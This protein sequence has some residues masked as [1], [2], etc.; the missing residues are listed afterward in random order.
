[1]SN[2]KKIT[3]KTF[4]KYLGTAL[5]GFGIG[6]LFGEKI[7]APVLA[8]PVVTTNISNQE[9]DIDTLRANL[10]TGLPGTLNVTRDSVGRVSNISYLNLS[11]TINRDSAGKISS[12]A[13]TIDALSSTITV[14]RDS[15]GRVSSLVTT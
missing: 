6:A 15:S 3:R 7:V 4:L 14:N 11:Q 12:I 2:N 13:N 10:V 5:T 8:T 1:M 9:I